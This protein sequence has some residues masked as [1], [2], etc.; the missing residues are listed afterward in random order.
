MRRLHKKTFWDVVVHMRVQITLILSVIALCCGVSL[1]FHRGRPNQQQ[2][3]RSRVVKTRSLSSKC[4]QNKRG[5]C[6]RCIMIEICLLLC[7]LRSACYRGIWWTWNCPGPGPRLPW[8]DHSWQMQP[9]WAY[10]GES[11]IL[12]LHQRCKLL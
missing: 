10:T 4:W 11:Q 3:V 2:Q 6:P 9:Q 7:V 12:S 5:M 8:L 1:I